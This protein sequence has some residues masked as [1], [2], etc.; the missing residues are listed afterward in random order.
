V[1]DHFFASLG[2]DLETFATKL[3]PVPTLFLTSPVFVF[4]ERVRDC[5]QN[6]GSYQ[7]VKLFSCVSRYCFGLLYGSQGLLCRILYVCG[8]R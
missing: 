4:L 8:R 7:T 1:I 5:I 2:F 3:Y 6:H